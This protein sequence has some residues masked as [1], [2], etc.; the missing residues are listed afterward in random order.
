MIPVEIFQMKATWLLVIC[1]C[2]FL[3]VESEGWI[4]GSSARRGR[5]R[6]RRFVQRRRYTRNSGF[7]R[8]RYSAWLNFGKHNTIQ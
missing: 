2:F 7:S 6:R 8:R 4:C 3:L 5:R 1:L